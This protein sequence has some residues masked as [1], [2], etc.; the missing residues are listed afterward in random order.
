VLVPR[1]VRL[2]DRGQDARDL[3]AVYDSAVAAELYP[4]AIRATA[5]GF[6]FNVGRIGSALAPFMVGSLAESRG[7][8]AAFALLALALLLGAATW[9]W[10]PETRATP[11]SSAAAAS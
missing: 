3:A 6:T 8:G 11:L 2:V 5:Q 7:F 4:T 9:I 10:L 1:A